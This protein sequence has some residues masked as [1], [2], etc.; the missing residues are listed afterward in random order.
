M[1]NK[2]RSFLTCALLVFTASL[3]I[4]AGCSKSEDDVQADPPPNADQY[5]T[6]NINGNKGYLAAPTDSLWLTTSYGPTVLFGNTA[7]NAA[8]NGG[9]FASVNATASGTFPINYIAIYT[10][11]KY[12]VTTSTAPQMNIATFGAVGQY[13]TGSYSGTVKDSTST[14]TFP[15][16][17]NFK[18]KRK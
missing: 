15:I 9:F 5:V 8:A 1:K 16:S 2:F 4:K 14:A 7:Y 13:V 11:D 18:I 6:W 10:N 17:G 12:Y 3:F